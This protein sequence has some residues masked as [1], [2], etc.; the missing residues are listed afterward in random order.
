MRVQS[1]TE[2][3]VRG[4]SKKVLLYFQG[5]G[6]W[7]ITRDDVHRT[8]LPISEPISCCSWNEASTNLG[9]CTTDAYP[10]PLL[11]ILSRDKDKNPRFADFTLVEVGIQNS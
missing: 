4:S 11:G 7:Y 10:T 1:I 2:K 9:L 5:G 6:A 8:I 3:V